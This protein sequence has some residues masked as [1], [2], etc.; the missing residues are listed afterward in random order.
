MT[1]HANLERFFEVM[2]TLFVEL[3]EGIRDDVF[4]AHQQDQAGLQR[5]DDTT[6]NEIVADAAA[7]GFIYSYLK[8]IINV[9]TR[10]I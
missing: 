5:V 7:S 4:S 8:Y 1:K 10:T 2:M 3:V 6:S 9:R